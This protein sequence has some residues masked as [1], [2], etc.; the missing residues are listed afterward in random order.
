MKKRVAAF[1]VIACLCA[2]AWQGCRPA[3]VPAPPERDAPGQREDADAAQDDQY[4]FL[5][6]ALAG[7]GYGV[8]APA[9]GD[10]RYRHGDTVVLKATPTGATQFAGWRFI[11]RSPNTETRHCHEP[12]QEIVMSGDMVAIA[13]FDAEASLTALGGIAEEERYAARIHTVRIGATH[14]GGTLTPPPG[15]YRVADQTEIELAAAPPEEMAFYHWE[16]DRGV[17][18]SEGG[19]TR[20]TI[21]GDVNMQAVFGPLGCRV[22]TETAGSGTG[23][24]TVIPEDPHKRPPGETVE[25]R[26]NPAPDAVFARWEGDLPADMEP[27]AARATVTLYEDKRLTAV[28]EKADY[29]LRV[30][31]A[32]LSE[33]TSAIILPAPGIHGYRADDE[34]TLFAAPPPDAMLAFAGWETEDGHTIQPNL[35]L[36]MDADKAVVAR[37]AAVADID[38]ITLDVAPPEGDGDGTLEPLGAGR[39]YFSR[40][41]EIVFSCTLQHDTYFAGWRGDFDGHINYRELP[42]VLSA[43]TV[44]GPRFS[45]SGAMVVVGL[46][47]IAG[48]RV[49]PSP[50]GYRFA[51]GLDIALTATRHGTGWQFQGWFDAFGNKLSPYGRY[52][53][54]ISAPVATMTVIGVFREHQEMHP[55]E[56]C[57][58]Q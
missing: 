28:F 40:G 22:I 48:G 32:G 20:M 12:V 43:D 11:E 47:G 53:F 35:T 16:S 7:A 23:A 52:V 19:A 25:L 6:V 45:R 54:Q 3:S 5:T 18:I 1:L 2:L 8:V 34:A 50:D 30:A 57:R 17:V 37:F 13:W 36:R 51:Y 27:T 26:A 24:V 14:D 58:A 39:Y 31:V 55:I 44:L 46:D 49:S 10:Y 15:V 9:P 42:V 38:A 21:V 33:D 29:Q 41:A 56:F 4:R